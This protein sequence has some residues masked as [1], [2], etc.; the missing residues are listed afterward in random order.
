MSLDVNE[1]PVRV[2]YEAVENMTGLE[3]PWVQQSDDASKATYYGLC[4]D[5]NNAMRLVNPFQTLD[6][7]PHGRHVVEHVP[8]FAHDLETILDCPRFK[9]GAS[10]GGLNDGET[11]VITAN[12]RQ[13]RNTI[14]ENADFA[15]GILTED[16]GI[17]PSRKLTRTLFRTFFDNLLYLRPNTTPGNV[18]WL[19][20]GALRTYP[21]YR[22]VVRRDSDTAKAILRNI[23]TARLGAGSRLEARPGH[24]IDIRFSLRRHR[25]SGEEPPRE[26][27]ELVVASH[28]KNENVTNLLE[29]TLHLR[30]PEFLKR[31]EARP[32]PTQRGQ[33]Y[34]DIARSELRRHIA[35]RPHLE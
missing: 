19:L 25:I 11:A 13:V 12:G 9:G 28:G 27:V 10:F 8:G 33:S 16:I 24:W 1:P 20:F 30:P 4:P 23:R 18:P 29:K 2:S 35:E 17:S 5:C 7:T 14:A 15:I 34:I 3:F 22:Q 26:T 6:L 32:A 31:I 21:L